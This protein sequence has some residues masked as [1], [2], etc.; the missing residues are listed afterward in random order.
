MEL[1]AIDEAY[2]PYIDRIIKESCGIKYEAMFLEPNPAVLNPHNA[3]ELFQNMHSVY[4]LGI[5][6]R[7]HFIGKNVSVAFINSQFS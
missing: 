6:E 3:L 2:R 5:L 4:V 7:S 1:K